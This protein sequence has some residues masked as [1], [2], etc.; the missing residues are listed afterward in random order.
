MKQAEPLSLRA[1]VLAGDAQPGDLGSIPG[2]S[3]PEA[4]R[5]AYAAIMED[6]LEN[7]TVDAER[8]LSKSNGQA[9]PL[10][11]TFVEL[12]DL[13]AASPA[14]GIEERSERDA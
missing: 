2:D 12:L 13:A 11:E 6:A 1:A 3:I 10:Q 5:L 14:E 8:I 9:E 4:Y 7:G